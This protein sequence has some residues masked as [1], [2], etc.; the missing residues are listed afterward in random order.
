MTGPVLVGDIGGTHL[1]FAW[2]T[3]GALSS[4]E[5]LLTAK[6]RS[7]EEAVRHFLTGQK[8]KPAAAAFS[9][10]GIVMDGRASMTNVDWVMEEGGLARALGVERAHII[11]DFA[12]AALGV[13]QLKAGELTQIGGKAPRGDAPKAVIGP[14]TGLGVGGLLPDG[15]GGFIPIS[16]EGGHVDLA[17]SNARELSVLEYLLREG[18][19]ISAERVLCG[20]GLEH[21]YRI[22]A[23]LDG[24][25]DAR[26]LTAA[27]IAEAAR[28]GQDARA[29]ETIAL[30]TGWLGAV[31][32]NVALTLGAHGGVYL[33]GGILPR[34]GTLFDTKLFRARFESKGRMKV[35]VAP[36]PVFLVN[37]PD[38]ALRGLAALISKE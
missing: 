38:L 20:E 7:L 22:L 18:G 34:W 1:R 27:E 30:F 8:Q 36:M 21:L 5:T 31:A 2:A 25:K 16:S 23:V 33:A 11:N 12:A 17:A 26:A 9:V 37:A 14:G 6:F 19:H 10:A 3:S 28:K 32:G 15:R 29:K 35:F 13:P 4:S 24:V